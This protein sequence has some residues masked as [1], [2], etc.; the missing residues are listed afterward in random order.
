MLARFL[1]IWN[2]AEA[3]IWL[4]V[5]AWL[6]TTRSWT[7]AAAIGCVVIGGW[8]GLRVLL[9][10]LS[11]LIAASAARPRPG[12][13]RISVLKWI[14][15]VLREAWVFSVAYAWYQARPMRF[16]R[17]GGASA[18]SEMTNRSPENRVPD[19]SASHHSAPDTLSPSDPSAGARPLVLLV[20]GYV[21]NGGVWARYVRW[22]DAA[23]CDVHTI[24]LEPLFGDLATI[25][26]SLEARIDALAR[27]YPGRQIQLVCHSMGGL[28]ARAYVRRCGGARLGKVITL[29]TPHQ[30][31][32][33]AVLGL[34]QNARQMH[35]D[36]AWMADPANRPPLDE[37]TAVFTYDDNLVSPRENATLD[38]MTR[39]ALSGIG[40]LSLTASR[41]VFERVL[42]EI[43][44]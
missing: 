21:C 22:F 39:I 34:G 12:E 9:N 40:H 42:A 5:A 26:R 15:A 37:A 17:E 3:L 16:G 4:A 23:G 30:G 43:K 33:L 36:S 19:N 29:G 18:A 13:F 10:A 2:F 35:S 20:H 32:A 44:G 28:V 1:R 8:F 25:S 14:A 27:Q 11:F 24:S 7:W 38:G 6:V 41:K 31:T